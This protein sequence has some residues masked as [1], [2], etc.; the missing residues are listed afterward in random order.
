MSDIDAD[1]EYKDIIE[2]E[3]QGFNIVLEDGVWYVDFDDPELDILVIEDAE[4]KYFEDILS[5]NDYEF[6]AKE[7]EELKSAVQQSN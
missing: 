3:Y 1:I 4:G 7:F 5:I 2:F 6:T